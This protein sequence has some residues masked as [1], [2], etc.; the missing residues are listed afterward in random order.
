MAFLLNKG[1]TIWSSQISRFSILF[2]FFPTMKRSRFLAGWPGRQCLATLLAAHRLWWRHRWRWWGDLV[3]LQWE[4][5]HKKKQV[6][7]SHE[8]ISKKRQQKSH[9]SA[10]QVNL[11]ALTRVYLGF[12]LHVAGPEV[13]QNLTELGQLLSIAIKSSQSQNPTWSLAQVERC[14][15]PQ[16]DRELDLVGV[17]KK[18]DTSY[19]GGCKTHH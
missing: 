18:L 9:Q 17:T 3:I 6:K 5:K 19:G 14:S 15:N 16:F 8:W 2:T 4:P 7:W 10:E 11:L 13:R 1:T 12:H